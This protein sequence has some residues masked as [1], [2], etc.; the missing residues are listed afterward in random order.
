MVACW[1]F[2]SPTCSAHAGARC[3]SGV[4]EQQVLA[5]V[6]VVEGR[7]ELADMARH[8]RHPFPVTV[9]DSADE[10]G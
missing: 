8:G 7:G 10:S 3:S 1:L 4:P 5:L 2:I 6:V 9:G